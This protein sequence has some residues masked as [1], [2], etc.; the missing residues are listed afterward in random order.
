M[1]QEPATPAS[2]N[3][4]WA[5]R[6]AVGSTLDQRVSDPLKRVFDVSGALG[7]LILFLP[8]LAVISLALLTQGGPLLYKHRRI[9][10][11]GHFFPCLKFR[12]MVV[13]SD[14]VLR[15]HLAS[16]PSAREEWASNQKLKYDPRVTALALFCGSPASTS[17]L[18][19]STFCWVT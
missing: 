6:S 3:T 11:G 2:A 4:S 12:T 5:K 13:D 7:L 15:R 8:L 17:Y 18:N 1:S 10:R 19:W 16:N 9:G 14:E